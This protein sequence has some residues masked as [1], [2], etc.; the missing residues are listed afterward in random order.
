[1]KV[2]LTDGLQEFMYRHHTFLR[3]SYT[4]FHVRKIC[5]PLDKS[6]LQMLNLTLLLFIIYSYRLA[7]NYTK[8]VG[9]RWLMS[10]PHHV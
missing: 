8:N 7:L 10:D 4:L 3:F 9:I 1:M 5:Q 2:R 6:E